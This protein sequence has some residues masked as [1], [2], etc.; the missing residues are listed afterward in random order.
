MTT[1]Q[2]RALIMLAQRR[3]HAGAGSRREFLLGRTA[4][5]QW[6]DL[7]SVLSPI[8]WAVVGA[9]ATRHYMPERMT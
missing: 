1:E 4:N 8:G 5:V 7:T 6:L 3:Q 2:R 9:V